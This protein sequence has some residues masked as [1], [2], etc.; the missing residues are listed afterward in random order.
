MGVVTP[1]SSPGTVIN[2]PLASPGLFAREVGGGGGNGG[3][4]ASV[5][6]QRSQHGR[7]MSLG[8]TA[9][10]RGLAAEILG[11]QLPPV[12]GGDGEDEGKEEVVVVKER[13][14]TKGEIKMKEM[15]AL[16]AEARRERKV[17]ASMKLWRDLV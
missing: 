4:R 1:V 13:Q 8:S 15:E 14:L 2:N 9:D 17:C 6:S 3:R 7:A 12:V 11:V 10:F 16:A 5:S